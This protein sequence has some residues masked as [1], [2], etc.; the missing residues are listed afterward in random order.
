MVWPNTSTKQET[1][2]M[3]YKRIPNLPAEMKTKVC[4]DKYERKYVNI[5]LS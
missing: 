4:I 5:H 2:R 3:K 1:K